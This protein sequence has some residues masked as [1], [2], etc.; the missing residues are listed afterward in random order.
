MNNNNYKSEAPPFG[1]HLNHFI[2]IIIIFNIKYKIVYNFIRF[3]I[4]IIILC[5]FVCY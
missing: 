2:I 5:C 1:S 4:I 3:I